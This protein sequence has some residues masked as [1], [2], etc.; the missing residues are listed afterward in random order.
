MTALFFLLLAIIGCSIGPKPI[1]VH[2]FSNL[3]LENNVLLFGAGYKLYQVDLNQQIA[4]VIYDTKD[5]VISFV[6]IDNKSLYFG[7]INSLEGGS[8]IWSFD[9]GNASVE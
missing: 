8:T 9:L 1:T 2:G 5:V 7:G 4:K 3:V 6:Q